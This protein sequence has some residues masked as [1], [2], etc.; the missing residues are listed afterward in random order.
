MKRLHR[1]SSLSSRLQRFERDNLEDPEGDDMEFNPQ[2][3]RRSIA[4]LVAW[5]AADYSDEA[6]PSERELASGWRR[7]RAAFLVDLGEE[8]LAHVVMSPLLKAGVEP[9]DLDAHKVRSAWER[10]AHHYEERADPTFLVGVELEAAL[11]REKELASERAWPQ[12]L[13][14]GWIQF[15]NAL[16]RIREVRPMSLGWLPEMPDPTFL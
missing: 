2:R 16:L 6:L 7:S 1:I 14:P 10:I 13:S 8:L 4:D 9:G 3:H 5:I 12:S 11:R 15:A